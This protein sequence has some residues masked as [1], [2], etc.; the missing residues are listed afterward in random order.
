MGDADATLE[1]VENAAIQPLFI[2]AVIVITVL[3]MTGIF[4]NTN[5]ALTVITSKKLRSVSNYL[6][7]A[8]AI[9]DIGHQISH[10][11]VLYSIFSG[12]NI[13]STTTCFAQMAIPFFFMDFSLCIMIWLALDRILVIVCSNHKNINKKIY[14]PIIIS[15]SFI[16]GLVLLYFAYQS[17]IA[18]PNAKVICMVVSI[19]NGG[20]RK[21]WLY[22]QSIVCML[23]V[24]M[25]V[26]FWILLKSKHGSELN[27]ATTKLV[28]RSVTIIVVIVLL[29]WELTTLALSVIQP[30]LNTGEYFSVIYYVG[31]IYNFSMSC[32]FLVLYFFK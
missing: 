6:I 27:D 2:P 11:F 30:Y 10:F 9:G 25:Y 21:I 19:F 20:S 13:T 22:S 12:Q 14:L 8:N 1:G 17:V 7:A 4:C 29:C 5:V 24:V 3:A 16:Y 23:C 18:V 26:V 28:A 31:I 15:T 32:N